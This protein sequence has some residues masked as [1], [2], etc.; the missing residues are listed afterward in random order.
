HS[1]S[2]KKSG[3]MS[4]GG[5]GVT[6]G[7]SK[8]TYTQD[9]ETRTEKA[10][11]VGSVLGSVNITA[12]KD[13]SIKSSD[14]VA[15]KDINLA[16]QN[17]HITDAA[18]TNSTRTAQSSSKSGL[19]LALSGVVGEAVNTAVQTAQAAKQED[20]SRLAALQGI[21]AGLSGYQAWQGAQA[22]ESGAQTGSFV[23]IALSL[24]TQKSS[25]KQLQEQS[26]SQGSSLTAGK[27]LTIIAVGDG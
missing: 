2:T 18:N 3:L 11:T 9:T 1:Q 24:G 15:D 6:L 12:G 23:G 16:G 8:N 17:V 19:T 25:S 26:V 5:I 14:I 4:S 22:L 21:K 13:L 27:D 20:D 7:S 10:S